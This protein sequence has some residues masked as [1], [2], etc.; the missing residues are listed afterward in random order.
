L[1]PGTAA[2]AGKHRAQE[3]ADYRKMALDKN[4]LLHFFT[5]CFIA[6][7]VYLH[8]LLFFVMEAMARVNRNE[9]WILTRGD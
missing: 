4:Y 7:V 2:A 6:V 1:R 8:A 5:S 9:A 3:Y